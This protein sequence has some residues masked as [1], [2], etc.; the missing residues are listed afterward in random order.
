MAVVIPGSALSRLLMKLGV[1]AASAKGSKLRGEG[2]RN[3]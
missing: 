1:G 2:L 3:A